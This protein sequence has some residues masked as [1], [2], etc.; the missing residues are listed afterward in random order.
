MST[1]SACNKETHD[2]RDFILYTASVNQRSG[3]V[4]SRGPQTKTTTTYKGIKKREYRICQ[5]CKKRSSTMQKIY[6]GASILSAL[7][8]STILF[9]TQVQGAKW[10]QFIIPGTCG[11]FLVLILPV[12]FL[13]RPFSPENRLKRRAEKAHIGKSPVQ[14]FTESEYRFKFGNKGR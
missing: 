10:H 3:L 7:L 13:L 12:Y 1:C 5:S 6:I 9:F 4:F 11:G 8:L 14:V 2:L